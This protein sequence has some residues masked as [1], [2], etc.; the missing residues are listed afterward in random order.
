[1]MSGDKAQQMTSH[2]MQCAS[3]PLVQEIARLKER[4]TIL[5][6]LINDVY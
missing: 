6:T 4:L 1:L 3:N 5:N 2:V